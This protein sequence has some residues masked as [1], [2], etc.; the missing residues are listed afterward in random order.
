M[1]PSYG[2]LKQKILKQ[3]YADWL[4][5]WKINKNDCLQQYLL[6]DFV[7]L[8]L[9]FNILQVGKNQLHHFLE[10]TKL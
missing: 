5:P 9:D 10:Y 6:L 1:V 2:T 7:K 8:T 4:V 3:V